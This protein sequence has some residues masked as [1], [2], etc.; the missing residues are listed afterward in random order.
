[1]KEILRNI[2]LH[3]FYGFLN[4]TLRNLWLFRKE[5][6][7][8][9]WRERKS[10]IN[11][12]LKSLVDRLYSGSWSEGLS[13]YTHQGIRLCDLVITLLQK[14]DPNTL[15]QLAEKKN[16]NVKLMILMRMHG[17]PG[18]VLLGHNPRTRGFRICD[19]RSLSYRKRIARA[20]KL[21]VEL[22]L[23]EKRNVK[24]Y[25][26]PLGQEVG[27]ELK[28]SFYWCV[29]E[30]LRAML[31]YFKWVSKVVW[32]LRNTKMLIGKKHSKTHKHR[33]ARITCSN[34]SQ[35]P[36]ITPNTSNK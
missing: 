7:P 6:R 18:R 34:A 9:S 27:F 10:Q 26:T 32:A 14:L 8:T 25:L 29:D 33:S 5:L 16:V 35:N 31:Y 20:L 17:H 13:Y 3:Q 28:S 21:L 2:L 36:K 30:P 24:Y 22:K 15:K 23:L 1:M 12:S 4:L 19:F 11:S